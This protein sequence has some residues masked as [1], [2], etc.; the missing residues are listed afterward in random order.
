MRIRKGPEILLCAVLVAPHCLQCSN[1]SPEGQVRKRL[2]GGKVMITIAVKPPVIVWNDDRDQSTGLEPVVVYR[3]T[4]QKSSPLEFRFPTSARVCAK[5]SRNG[6]ETW[7]FPMPDEGRKPS[8]A[9]LTIPPGKSFGVSVELS[10]K[11]TQPHGQY[12]VTGG[13]CGYPAYQLTV[14]FTVGGN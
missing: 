11:A 1:P 6:K 5:V 13:L 3:V 10:A 9:A 12:S 2:E 14:G 4:N 7:L 8:A